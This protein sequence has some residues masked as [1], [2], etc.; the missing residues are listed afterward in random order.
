M[1]LVSTREALID[2]RYRPFSKSTESLRLRHKAVTELKLILHGQDWV[3]PNA[4]A[5]VGKP[6]QVTDAPF[7]G[8][9]RRAG[10]PAARGC[11]GRAR[12]QEGCL[13]RRTGA[14]RPSGSGRPEPRVHIYGRFCD[15]F[16]R[17]QGRVTLLTKSAREPL[18]PSP[19]KVD[20]AKD[21]RHGPPLTG[22]RHSEGATLYRERSFPLQPDRPAIAAG[23]S[24]KATRAD[25][26]VKLA[27]L[28]VTSRGVGRI[29]DGPRT[30]PRRLPAAHH[31]P[32]IATL[33]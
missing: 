27:L 21:R 19:S 32:P 8:S 12:L 17:A 22:Q 25:N 28:R 15:E 16:A 4:P 2:L 33:E 24:C 9:A 18:R 7:R 30:N 1:A 11:R 20:P 26:C 29:G 23:R 31:G 10:E 14:Q 3:D 6:A 13:P 5:T